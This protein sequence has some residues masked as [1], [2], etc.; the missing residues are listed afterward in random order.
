MISLEWDFDYA[1]ILIDRSPGVGALVHLWPQQLGLSA[2]LCRRLEEWRRRQ[3]VLSGHWMRQWFQGEGVGLGEG[4]GGESK[5]SRRLQ[6][7]LARDRLTLAWEVQHELG[8][9]VQVQVN[10]RGLRQHRAR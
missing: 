7:Q 1:S 6:E 10:G 3:E 5:E 2:R 9:D 4:A 8:E